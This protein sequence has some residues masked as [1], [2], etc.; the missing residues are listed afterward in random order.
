[1]VLRVWKTVV[2]ETGFQDWGDR[3]GMAV[4]RQ[5]VLAVQRWSQVVYV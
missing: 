3:V 5:F 2:A 1:V 4:V